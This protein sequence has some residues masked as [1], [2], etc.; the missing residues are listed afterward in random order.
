M[1]N[2]SL[3]QAS[4]RAITSTTGSYEGDWQALFD[5][6]SIDGSTFNE[7]LLG[8]INTY[9]SASYT[10]LVDAQNAFAVENGASN[11]DSLGTFEAGIA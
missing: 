11:W 5:E 3:K 6:Y 10:N 8:Y 7:R 2:Q 9:L 1:S 4:V